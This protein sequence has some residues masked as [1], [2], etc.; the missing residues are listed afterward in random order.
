MVFVLLEENVKFGTKLKIDPYEII[1]EN[2]F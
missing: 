2:K 1:F